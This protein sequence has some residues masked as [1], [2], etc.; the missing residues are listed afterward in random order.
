MRLALSTVGLAMA[1]LGFWASPLCRPASIA[2]Q[3]AQS[4]TST[5]AAP[6]NEQAPG[7]N[8]ALL[9][10]HTNLV[11]VDVVVTDRGGKPVHGLGKREFHILEDGREKTI[12]TFDEHKP[13]EATSI[14]DGFAALKA[15]PP[16]TFS[17]VPRYPEAGAMNVLLLDGLN[18]PLASQIDVR[19]QMIDYMG[20]I[21]PGTE[22]AIFVLSSRLRMVQAFTT[23]AAELTKAFKNP[24]LAQQSVVLDPQSDQDLDATIGDMATLGADQ[25]ALDSMRQFA[26][27][28]T[29]F[30]VD[31]RVQIT[32]DAMQQLARYLNGVPGRKNLIWF[33]GSFP[34]A[35][36]P[37]D[38]LISPF[39][40][41]RNY[42]DQ[43]RETA[44]LLS[45]ARVAVYPVDARG[46]MTPA[47]ADAS[48]APSSN[49]V[50]GGS[51]ANRRR[52]GQAGSASGSANRPDVG[53]DDANSMKQNMMEQASMEQIAEETGG[54]DY[55]NTN[56]LK[57]AVASAVENGSSYY[58]IGYVPDARQLDGSFRKI[59]LRAADAG[60]KL[61][62]RRGY[63]ADSVDMP[64]ARNP[65]ETSLIQA[66]TLHGAP[67]ATQILFEARVLA[68]DDPLLKGSKV[69]VGAAGD[70]TATLK[71]PLHRVIVDIRA[72]AHGFAY[73]ETTGGAHSAKVEFTL[74]AYDADG[75]R[76]NYLDRGFQLNL[77]SAQFTQTMKD[78]IP[79]RLALDLPPGPAFL[80]IAVH[81]LDAGRVGSLEVRVGDT[82]GKRASS[83]PAAD[84]DK[85]SQ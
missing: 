69:P 38:S 72:D 26:A 14:S 79:I 33:S 22:L 24:Q 39:E 5:A 74:V 62:Y 58:T 84:D 46:L 61:S 15:L 52:R 64:S 71:G 41:L 81:D 68:A 78:G 83:R 60:Y 37:D 4:A 9:R 50:G 82:A 27:E 47:S 8:P 2:A 13:D 32:L 59:E 76:V 21:E 34:L 7:S 16:H 75:K 67:P 70:M 36:D 56:G 35:L 63:Y 6:D 29:A 80:R 45:A 12:S 43:I 31:Q 17:N 10:A 44:E 85:Q 19:R 3:A 65:G 54:Q 55:I 66:A 18:T 20:K 53:K 1:G 11:L 51:F 48:Y 57:Q 42:S 40:V 77:R 30:Q 28:Q 49:L 73:V 25:D 23:E